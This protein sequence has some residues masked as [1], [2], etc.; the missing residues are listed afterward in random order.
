MEKFSSKVISLFYPLGLVFS[1]GLLILSACG[2]RPVVEATPTSPLEATQAVE[3]VLVVATSSSTPVPRPTNTPTTTPTA[4]QTPIPT[5]TPSP[6]ST[7]TPTPTPTPTHPL[8][9]QFMRQQD[10]PGSEITIE[11]TLEAGVNYDRYLVSYLSEGNKIYALLTIPQGEKPA[12]GWPVVIFN[13]GYIPPAQY[14]T[15]ERYVAYVDA[16]ARNGYIVLRSD[17]RGHGNSEGEATGGYGSPAYTI[18]VLNAVA[19]VK[20]LP[21]TDPN[22]IGMWGHSMGGQITLRA[23]VTTSDIKA[24]IIW[25]GV[26]ASYPDMLERWRR[27]SESSGEATPTP[28]PTNPRRRWRQELVETYGSPE[29]NP[30]FWASISP[31][32]YLSDLSGPIQLHH[33]TADDSV[34]VEF[35]ETLQAEMEAAGQLVELYLYENDNHNISNNFETAMERSIQFFDK[36][37]KDSDAVGS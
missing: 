18:D 24:G 2:G 1:L 29:E 28:D 10:Y 37:V 33:G 6:T 7:S 26:V 8:M 31:N 36:Y 5:N 14:R 15:T 13:H 12:S 11:E 25:A 3:V 19:A 4:T 27:R 30:E 20:T 21:E 9:I 16:F 17:Y 34:P 35:S 22:R 23:M 32:S